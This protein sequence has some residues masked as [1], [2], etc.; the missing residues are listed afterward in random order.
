MEPPPGTVTIA[1]TGEVIDEFTDPAEAWKGT[2]TKDRRT[3]ASCTYATSFEFY[4]EELEQDL[5]VY[6]T[7]TVDGFSTPARR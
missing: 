5:I 7:G 6:F 4:D 1:D 3:S 2:A